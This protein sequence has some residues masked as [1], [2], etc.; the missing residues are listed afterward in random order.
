MTYTC[1]QAHVYSVQI[2]VNRA[3]VSRYQT[4]AITNTVC[5]VHYEAHLQW[6]VVDDDD[7]HVGWDLPGGHS[8]V[9]GS[10]LLVSSEHPDLDVG[11]PQLGY[12]LR[13][14]LQQSRSVVVSVLNIILWIWVLE[15]G[16]CLATKVLIC[17][18]MVSGGMTVLL[19]PGTFCSLSSTAVAPS[20]H[21]SCSRGMY[22]DTCING[23]SFSLTFSISSAAS[24][25]LFSRSSKATLAWWYLSAQTWTKRDENRCYV[26]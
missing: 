8:N 4:L 6:L 7:V 17:K 10:L 23:N 18:Y 21:S 14:S 19:T 24:S 1:T 3:L 16:C 9:D 11:T 26:T 5:P 2:I 13:D 15:A 22:H 12:A 25:S 20:R